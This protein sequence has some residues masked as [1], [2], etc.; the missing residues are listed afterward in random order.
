MTYY[1]YFWQEFEIT[2]V[3]TL[4]EQVEHT[5][6]VLHVIVVEPTAGL[7]GQQRVRFIIF[8]GVDAHRAV[9]HQFSYTILGSGKDGLFLVFHHFL[10]GV[11]LHQPEVGGPFEVGIGDALASHLSI[12]V[13]H[14]HLHQGLVECLFVAVEIDEIVEGSGIHTIHKLVGII[15]DDTV[16]VHQVLAKLIVKLSAV[17]KH[18][19]EIVSNARGVARGLLLAL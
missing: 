2:L 16:V 19:A 7:D 13:H 1:F 6:E 17:E 3:R 12:V 15:E 11:R 18:A 9:E 8:P 10:K 14:I 4:I 5:G